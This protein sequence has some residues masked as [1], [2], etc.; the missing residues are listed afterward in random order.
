[1]IIV[2]VSFACA[3]KDAKGSGP[4]PDINV[5]SNSSSR[6]DET[7]IMEE[8][9]LSAPGSGNEIDAAGGPATP[10][11][12]DNVRVADDIAYFTENE[13]D[14]VYTIYNDYTG[15]WDDWSWDARRSFSVDYPVYD[16]DY[17]LSLRTTA[18]WGALYLQNVSGPF[19][20]SEYT[21]IRFFVH[22]GSAG[23]QKYSLKLF[24]S[25]DMVGSVP[26]DDYVTKGSV[27]ANEW[28]MVDIPLADIGAE[29]TGLIKLYL[30]SDVDV[31]QPVMYIDRIEIYRK[32]SWLDPRPGRTK[33]PE[34]QKDEDHSFRHVAYDDSTSWGNWSWGSDID[35]KCEQYV[36][37]GSYAIEWKP[38]DAWA[39]F[40]LHKDDGAIDPGSTTFMSFYINGGNAGYQKVAIAFFDGETELRKID[41]SRYIEGGK[42]LPREWRR[43]EIPLSVLDVSGVALERFF[44]QSMAETGQPALYLD[45]IGFY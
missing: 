20:T 17:S 12:A 13:A 38:R 10:A 4:G 15:E 8:D 36:H 14:K 21:N 43:V 44:I 9:N 2:L 42:I 45:S 11:P 37:S 35:F 28:R 40:S 30:Q 6:T 5:L 34:E 16:G 32:K 22:G 19:D 41:F 24:N 18:G 3:R 7:G 33:P 25:D 39:G 27:A 23:K 29:N 31:M 1:M 26:V